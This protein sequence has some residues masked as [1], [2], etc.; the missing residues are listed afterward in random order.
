[1]GQKITLDDFPFTVVGVAPLGFTGLE[2]G[3]RPDLWWPVRAIPLVA[4]DS[5]ALKDGGYTWLKVMGRLQPGM[6]LARA[7]AEMEVF[8]KQ[9]AADAATKQS[10]LPPEQR[11]T[12]ELSR[13]ELETGST[14]WSTLRQQ[15]KKPLLILMTVVVLVLLI[16]CA[17]VANLLLA[18]A[19]A[20]RKEIAVRLALGASRR[21]LLRQLIT[22][23]LL[24]ALLGG[25][26]G[27]VFAQWGTSVLLTYLPRQNPVI[28]ALRPDARVL[29]FTLVASL[30]T[31]LLFGLAPALQATK[32]ELTNSL[33]D[34]AGASTHRTFGLRLPLHKA[35]VVTQMALSLFLLIGAG[36]FVRSL[37]NLKTIDLGFERE[38][39]AEFRLETGKGYNGVQRVN[40]YK[41]ILAK[42]EALPGVQ[43]ASFSSFSLLSDNRTYSKVSVA[44]LVAQSDDDATCNTLMVGPNYFATMGIPL[45][46]GREFGPQD[47]RP[48][49]PNAG[50]QSQAGRGPLAGVINQ[51]MARH[52]FG[53]KDPIGQRFSVES[54]QQ[55]NS[56]IEIVGVVKD[57]KYRNMREAAPRTFYLAW[58]QQ[59]GNSN[60]TFQLRTS[61]ATANLAATIQHVAQEL[62]PKLQI[63]GLSTMN[64][65]VDELL[66]QQRFIAQVAGFFS[67]FAL[68]LAC[69][70]LYGIM[71]QAVLRRTREIGVR[72][73]LGAQSSDV[74]RLLLREA[75]TLVLMGGVVG[76]L[77]SLAATQIASSLLFGLKPN[78]PVT[79]ICATVLLIVVAALAGYLPARR[80]AQVDPMVALRYE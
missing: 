54:S 11:R 29:V 64:E 40:L 25:A 13:L 2:V 20:R 12:S 49:D 26:A 10:S 33:R 19:A 27:L 21:R 59:P 62:D 43:S 71:A 39:L 76:L 52:F 18:R 44:G 23:S 72:M 65:R 37:Q 68:L 50:A 61:V 4:P 51:T 34:H 3:R 31:G 55:P 38:N 75:L 58:F 1:V 5:P 53:A 42:L 9:Q 7:Q 36:L 56:L 16:A 74:L 78:D 60:Q 57:A 45:L 69:L 77:A 8:F 66:V 30:L 48:S 32:I 14:G 70:G 73:A 46:S 80:A 63:V 35:L 28:L 24:L 17:N 22:E 47:E 6:S 79:I 67:L 15:L 41:Q